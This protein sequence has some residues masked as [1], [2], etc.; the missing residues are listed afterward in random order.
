MRVCFV[1]EYLTERRA[2]VV[3]LR[4]R[5]VPGSNLGLDTGY[6]EF[7]VIFLSPSSEC[8]HSTIKLGHD[9]FLPN[10]F[11]CIFHYHSLFN[12]I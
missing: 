4:I 12:A 10:P 7:F 3:L 5:E 11:R 8:R 2:R 9:C 1:T 6:T